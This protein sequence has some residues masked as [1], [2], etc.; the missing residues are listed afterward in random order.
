[1]NKE[2]QQWNKSKHVEEKENLRKDYSD[3]KQ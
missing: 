2:T 1:M 3:K